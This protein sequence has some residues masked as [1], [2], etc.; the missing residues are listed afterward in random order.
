MNKVL[1]SVFLYMSD[2]CKVRANKPACEPS[3]IGDKVQAKSTLGHWI[4]PACGRSCKV[5]RKRNNN[6]D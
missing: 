2:C 3:K 5:T 6:V 1:N 4:C